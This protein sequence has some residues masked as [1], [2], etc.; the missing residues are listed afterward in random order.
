MFQFVRLK[1]GVKNWD[2]PI[3]LEPIL[4]DFEDFNLTNTDGYF[5]N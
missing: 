4:T 5:K 1:D 3:D 2:R